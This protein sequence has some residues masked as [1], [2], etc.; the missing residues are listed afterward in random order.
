MESIAWYGRRT[1][2]ESTTRSINSLKNSHFQLAAFAPDR[3]CWFIKN[4]VMRSSIFPPKSCLRSR[5]S[6]DAS[7]KTFDRSA[8][9]RSLERGCKN[10]VDHYN[11]SPSLKAI[12]CHKQ[13]FWTSVLVESTVGLLALII[14]FSHWPGDLLWFFN[15]VLFVVERGY[16]LVSL[17]RQS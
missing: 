17:P 8:V 12:D 1:L 13:K 16:L 10:S 5:M 9:K 4:V 7:A 15:W 3:C 2:F 14:H 11:A 6:D